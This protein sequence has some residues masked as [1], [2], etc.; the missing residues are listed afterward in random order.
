MAPSRVELPIDALLPQ[1]AET[2]RKQS[3]LVLE[4]PPGAGKTTRVPGAVLPLLPEGQVVLVLQPRRLAT[5]LEATS[6]AEEMGEPV[7]QTV[8][9]QVR[10][11]DMSSPRTRIRFVTEGILSRRLLGDPAL[12]KVRVVIFDQF[13]EQH[14]ASDIGLAMVCR[15][16]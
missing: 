2:L 10:F 3:T 11:E 13:H 12:N 4:S 6:I 1:L 8:G 15:L 7:G 16:K 5:R 9:Y 14:F